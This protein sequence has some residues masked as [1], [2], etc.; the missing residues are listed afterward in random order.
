[1]SDFKDRLKALDPVRILREKGPR[2]WWFVPPALIGALVLVLAV[3]LAPGASRNDDEKPP[4][5]VRVMLIASG[6]VEPKLKAYGVVQPRQVWQGVA[7]VSG[8]V[9]WRSP[10][11]RAGATLPAGT[12]LIEI[13]PLDYEVA[14]SRQEAQ[15]RTATAA[16]AEVASRAADLAQALQIETR[17]LEIAQADYERNEELAEQ[18]HISALA[19]DAQERDLLRQRQTL[20]NLKTEINL[21]P[22][23]ERAADARVAEAKASLEK[24]RE[25]L[26]RTVVRMPFNG[27]IERVDIEAGQFVPAGR[28]MLV[29]HSTR[30]VEVLVEVPYNHLVARFPSIMAHPERLADSGFPLRAT[31]RHAV[32]AS[33]LVWHG[34]VSRIDPGLDA[35][36]RSAR[37]Y[38]TVDLT[39]SDVA[40]A[41]NLY[42]EADISGP[43]LDDHVVIPRTAWHAGTVLIADADNRLHKR[44]V[45]AAFREENY[46]V[47][48]D[49]L[50]DGERLILTDVL[51]P[52]DGLAI[53]P[54]LVEETRLR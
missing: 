47:I 19:L 5:P 27:R 14:V 54:I 12:R 16:T 50:E 2:K 9:A 45:D 13:E 28:A 38:V 34:R 29:A 36:S 37:V 42:V 39:E 26:G 6:T 52:A 3:A 15:L 48:R 31:L 21:L 51:F 1:M 53:S 30:D 40:P 23:Q 10:E 7:Q 22:A 17:A 41:T 35:N 24:A 8:K 25:D 4:L 33:E 44:E 20:Q 46:V 32:D 11:L 18:G 43:L 49:G